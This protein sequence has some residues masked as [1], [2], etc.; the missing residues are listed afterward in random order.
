MNVQVVGDLL[1]AAQQLWIME[2]VETWL[3]LI[4]QVQK[5]HGSAFA[6]LDAR[7]G[8][9]IAS[10]PRRSASTFSPRQR[11]ASACVRRSSP[12][13]TASATPR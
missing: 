12:S 7:Q 1:I 4:A 3:G 9:T 13:G 8:L 6:I 10:A 5:E 2:D 11:C